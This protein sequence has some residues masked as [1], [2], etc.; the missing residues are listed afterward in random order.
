[1]PRVGEGIP[2][3]HSTGA[4]HL[5][6]CVYPVAPILDWLRSIYYTDT[7]SPACP[8]RSPWSSPT[9][10]G[11]LGWLRDGE[12]TIW[13]SGETKLTFTQLCQAW[14]VKWKLLVIFFLLLNQQLLGGSWG[15]WISGFCYKQPL[16]KEEVKGKGQTP[17]TWGRV[18]LSLSARRPVTGTDVGKEPRSLMGKITSG[19]TFCHALLTLMTRWAFCQTQILLGAHHSFKIPGHILAVK[20]MRD[21]HSTG[22]SEGYGKGK[23]KPYRLWNLESLCAR[24]ENKSGEND[25]KVVKILPP[26]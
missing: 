21:A 10:P 26:K 20:G 5:G 2:P 23:R 1:M 11:N 8:A 18:L 7:A 19:R 12:Q 6:E 22:D 17:H 13:V 15:V 3:I 24:S 25:V 4:Q 16:Y 14:C 9:L